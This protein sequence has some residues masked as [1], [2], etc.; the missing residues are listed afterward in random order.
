[1]PI[2]AEVGQRSLIRIRMG[3]GVEKKGNGNIYRNERV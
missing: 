3:D 2:V 1:M